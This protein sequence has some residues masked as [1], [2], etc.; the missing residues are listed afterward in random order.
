MKYVY[1]GSHTPNLKIIKPHKS[2]HQQDFIYASYSKAVATI[3][4]SPKHSDLYYFLK[5]NGKDSKIILVER[6]KGMFKDIFNVSGSIYTLNNTDFLENMTGWSA[7][8]VSRKEE[9][10]I[11]EE[12]ITNVYEELLELNRLGE[13]ELY[14]YPNRPSYVPLD[15]S[16]LIPKVINWS[17]KGFNIEKFFELYPE[18]VDRFYKELEEY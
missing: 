1:H 11:K 16:D 2:T 6:K 10:V 12:K 5:G 18:L 14:L 17:K 8:V 7:E 15:N 9:E 3:F 4:L 13:L